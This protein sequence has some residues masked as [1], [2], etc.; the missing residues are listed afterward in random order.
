M[1]FA[2][3]L[4]SRGRPLRLDAGDHLFRQ[5]DENRCLYL[6]QD[7]LLKAYYVTAAGREYTKSFIQAGDLIGSLAAAYLREPCSFSL[8]AL[9]EARALELDFDVLRR[10]TEEDLELASATVDHLL[11]F[12]MKKERREHDFLTR[13][14]QERYRMLEEHSP[15]ILSRVTQKDIA[16]YLGI[17]PVAL[18]RI[19]GRRSK[20]PVGR[21][22]DR[23]QAR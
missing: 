18:S 2:E 9:E 8:V 17:T 15:E 20:K 12:A 21:P 23:D 6:L 3:F 10:A 16:L 14:A 1:K 22:G 5:G 19:R 4:S 13:S 7:G 11:R